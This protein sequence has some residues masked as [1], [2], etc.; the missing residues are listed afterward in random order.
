MGVG[1]GMK[2]RLV[3]NDT[4]WWV[5][6]RRGWWDDWH[7]D[8]MQFASDIEARDRLKVIQAADEDRRKRQ[9]SPTLVIEV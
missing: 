2:Y 9:A 4:Y 8:I 7:S 5:Q 6:S 3:F 1:K